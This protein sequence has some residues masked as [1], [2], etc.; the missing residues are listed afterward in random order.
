MYILY[1][2][3]FTLAAFLTAPYFVFRMRKKGGYGRSLFKML[4]LGLDHQLSSLG[5]ARPVWIHAVSVGEVRAAIPLIQRLKREHT[6]IKLVLSTVTATGQEMARKALPEIDRLI[7]FPFDISWVVKRLISLVRPRLFITL[8]TEIWPNFLRALREQ[9]I[10][11]VL[12]NGRIS[13]RSYKGYRLLRG[14][15]NKVLA[16][17]SY[18][19]MQSA[20]DAERI[21]SLGANPA[22]LMVCGNMKYDQAWGM[23]DLEAEKRAMSIL[24][25]KAGTRILVA[26]S[27]HPGEEEVIIAAY[28]ELK[29]DDSGLILVLAP[30]HPER[31]DETEKLMRQNGL[32]LTRRSRLAGVNNS[33]EAILLDSIGEL[34]TVYA[35]AT[36][37]FIGGSLVP[38][39]GHNP[40]EAAAFSKPVLFGPHMDNFKDIADD[41]VEKGGAIMVRSK[42]ELAQQAS[43]LLRDPELARQL[44][45]CAART[46]KENIGATSATMKVINRF[47]TSQ[48]G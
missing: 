31:F 30:R 44:G 23:D 1:N 7:Y 28:Q 8:E 13:A 48:G 46:I 40:L 21:I 20:S 47:L 5:K 32:K 35:G 27:T 33:F 12:V 39:G 24:G 14:F 9:A 36:V 37:V 2:S 42:K 45:E 17:F 29:R 18:L 10:P 26:G 22:T 11:A 34:S 4:G 3:L 25:L 38:F 6:D 16:C 41:L 43:A 15:F 19:C